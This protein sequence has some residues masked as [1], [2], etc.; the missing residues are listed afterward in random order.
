MKVISVVE[1]GGLL[2]EWRPVMIPIVNNN[3]NNAVFM[4]VTESVGR[5][6]KLE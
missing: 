1:V 3:G 5:H 4:K 6:W 2:A